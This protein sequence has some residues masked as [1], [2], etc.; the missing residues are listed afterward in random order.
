YELPLRAIREQI[1]SAVDLIVHTARLRDGTRR[2]V[3]ISEV[4]GIEDDE[5]LMQDIF[6]FEQTAFVDGK[7]VGELKPTGI[8][9]TFMGIFKANGIEL[10]PGEFGIG[11]I[12]PTKPIPRA[13]TRFQS[14]ESEQAAVA[15]AA[16]I[17][18]GK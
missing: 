11:P 18:L 3:N 15:R 6:A 16:K 17:G 7:V 8:R 5:I 4:Y 13:K 14:F 9:P 12:D 2:I 10:P 1:A